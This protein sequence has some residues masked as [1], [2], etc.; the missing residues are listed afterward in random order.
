MTL[1]EM[2]EAMEAYW[3]RVDA[4]A[5]ELKDSQLALNRLE[6]LYRRLDAHERG[7]AEVVISEWL[8]SD[9]DGRRFD[10]EVLIE[11]CRIGSA[12]PALRRLARK[13]ETS[14][15]PG[16]PFERERVSRLLAALGEPR[17]KRGDRRE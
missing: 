14:A 1:D 11:R 4:E 12:A 2:R 8:G 17:G 9:D 5:R 16:A 3:R 15:E 10:A 6:S 13:L 7:L